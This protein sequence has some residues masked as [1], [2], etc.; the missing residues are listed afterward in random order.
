V[1]VAL[2]GSCARHTAHL[3]HE[4]AY[5]LAVLERL[6]ARRSSW[7]RGLCTLRCDMTCLTISMART[8][9]VCATNCTR[10]TTRQIPCQKGCQAYHCAERRQRALLLRGRRRLAAH[11]RTWSLLIRPPRHRPGKRSSCPP[12]SRPRQRLLIGRWQLEV[13]LLVSNASAWDACQ[14]HR[15]HSSNNG[16]RAQPN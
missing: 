13:Q 4:L 8:R 9:L 3:P 2:H 7:R 10:T 16:W 15:E 1:L 11:L 5:K 12:T 14:L 6:L